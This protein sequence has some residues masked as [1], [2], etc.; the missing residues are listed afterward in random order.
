LVTLAE[1]YRARVTL[2]ERAV[3]D[4][5]GHVL[6]ATP[7]PV[8]AAS[9]VASAREAYFRGDFPQAVA[10]LEGRTFDD[11]R[12]RVE[13]LFILS[14]ALLR[15]QRSAKVVDLLG[16]V[17]P[18]FSA[19]DEICTARMLYGTAI[20]L[21]RDVD[22]GLAILFA[23]AKIADSKRADRAIRAELAYFQGVAH[24]TKHE[25]LQ[26]ST[27]AKQAER[28]ATDVLSVRATQLRAFAALASAKF[29]KA[30]KLFERARKAYAL[31]R[32]RD[33]DLATQIIV[34]IAF[35][36]MN[37]RSA[38]VLGSH[39]N[40]GGRTIPGTS[41]GPAIATSTRMTLTSA[42]AWLYAHD[43]DRFKAFR[44]IY[45][46]LSIAPTPAWR[47]WAL[48]SG[49]ALFQAFGEIGNAHIFADDA[50]KI[51]VSMDWNATSD[52]ERISLMRL[53]EVYA[54]DTP[55][56][57][58]AMLQR[59]DTITSKMDPT[60]LLRDRHADP[61]LA[62]W[63]AHVRGMVARAVGE[64]E[65]AG[66]WF[67]KAVELFHSCGYLWREA[68]ALIELDATPIDTRGE[69][70]LERAAIL[71]R[72]NFPNSFLAARLGPNMQAYMDPVARTLTPAER[73]VLRRLIAGKNTAAI[74][75]ETNR[76]RATVKRHL[77]KIHGAFGT[78]STAELLAECQRR[79]L[80]L[81]ALTYRNEHQALPK[82]S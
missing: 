53:A 45:E 18:T 60:R 50:A 34:Q 46:A 8:N 35:L 33:L 24:W 71:I 74:A 42:D 29:G 64:H 51:A 54:V 82:T 72:D 78:H 66:A 7:L 16:P 59:Y 36:E 31:C 1:V 65:R 20:A 37:L 67:R 30:L 3:K 63:D 70:P 26:T 41:F 44:K 22:Q 81:A 76:A 75:A 58:P 15:L 21:S 9:S 4:G 62:G 14:R 38:K 32:G 25:Y 40:P 28:S 23:T 61:R 10:A 27:Y 73:D 69:V 77:L 43:G 57:A 13:A 11:P 79:G 6:P 55:A 2:K 49:A 52:E 48:T 17:L 56:A 39:A 19:T 12:L 68:L 80:G 5:T 47:V